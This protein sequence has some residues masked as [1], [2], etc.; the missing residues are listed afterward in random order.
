MMKYGLRMEKRG[1]VL[2]LTFAREP[3]PLFWLAF[4]ILHDLHC[5][6]MNLLARFKAA[7]IAHDY[8]LALI[9]AGDY[10]GIARRLYSQGDWAIL[11]FAIAVYDKDRCVVAF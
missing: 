8:L 5:L 11:N 9:Q 10:L 4:L 6:R 1:H 3:R 2:S 7:P